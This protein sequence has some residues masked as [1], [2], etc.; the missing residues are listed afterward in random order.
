MFIGLFNIKGCGAYYGGLIFFMAGV[1]IGL[2]VPYFGIVFLFSHGLVGLCMMIFGLCGNI[3]NILLT[4]DVNVSAY[5]I[6][7]IAILVF[8]TAFIS[9]VLYNISNTFSSKMYA[10][11]IIFLIYIIGL[12]I[13]GIL[14]YVI[15]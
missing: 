5:V 2:Y 15:K 11:N 14:P 1:F 3:F 13:A 4:G 7:A 8:I 10:K 12:L 9:V 6:I